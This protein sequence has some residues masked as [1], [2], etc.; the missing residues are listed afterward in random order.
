M[1]KRLLLPI[2]LLALLTPCGYAT[3][4][5]G[6]VTFDPP[7]VI[8]LNQGFEIDLIKLICQHLNQQCE[9]IPMEY[10]SLF[11]ELNNNNIDIAIDGI[12]F[13]K[14]PNP[15]DGHYIF[16]LPYLLSEGQFLVLKNSGITKVKNLPEGSKVGLIRERINASKGIF[17]NFLLI[18]ILSLIPS[19]LRIWKR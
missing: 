15:L 6:T 14:A 7:Y 4:K 12:D 3:I 18:T 11:R 17:Y 10:F 2:L 16:S 5:V 9:L 13:Y 19:F 1:I 8:S